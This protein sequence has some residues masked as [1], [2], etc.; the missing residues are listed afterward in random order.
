MSCVLVFVYNKKVFV[1]FTLLLLILTSFVW[2][3][4]F[5]EFLFGSFVWKFC[6]EA[7]IGSF[8]WKF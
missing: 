2:C 8:V 4:L 7:L 1:L 5:V 6:F 3:Y